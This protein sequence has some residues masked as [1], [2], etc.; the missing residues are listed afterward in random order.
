MA[1]LEREDLLDAAVDVLAIDQAVF[2]H[3]HY[4]VY[5]GI[6]PWRRRAIEQNVDAGVKYIKYLDK[7]FN[8]NL[9]KTLAAYNAGEGN[10]K[11]YGGIPPFR[12]TQTY[13]KKVLKNY[14]RRSKQ[15]EKFEQERIGGS[16]RLSEDAVAAK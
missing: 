14:D 1:K 16:G 12:E 3:R 13:V 11:R 9:K 15:L 7:R 5:Q 2:D 4:V 6:P 8:G 10:V